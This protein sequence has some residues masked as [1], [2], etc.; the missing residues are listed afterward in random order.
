MGSCL[1]PM[2]SIFSKVV[3]IKQLLLRKVGH[4]GD[5]LDGVSCLPCHQRAKGFACSHE[6]LD[7]AV[8]CKQVYFILSGPW[9]P[10]AM[11]CRSPLTIAWCGKTRHGGGTIQGASVNQK[12]RVVVQQIR[13]VTARIDELPAQLSEANM[14]A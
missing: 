13:G 11:V 14:Q 10:R 12:S 2:S 1:C 5:P 6:V 4:N 7:A 3:F 9:C 8:D